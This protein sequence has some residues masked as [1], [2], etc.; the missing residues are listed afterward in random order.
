MDSVRIMQ[1]FTC[2]RREHPKLLADLHR[3]LKT[4]GLALLC[5]GAG[6]LPEDTGA[7]QGTDVLESL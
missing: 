2:P 4:G 1:L 3:V 7:Y 6:D 5:M